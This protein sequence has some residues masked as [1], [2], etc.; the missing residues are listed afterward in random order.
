M[1][2]DRILLGDMNTEDLRKYGYQV[3]D[4]IVNYIANL[5]K[6]PV[7]AQVEPGQI[8]DAL[9]RSPPETSES[10]DSILKDLDKIILPGITHWNHPAFF[11]YFS[12]SGSAPGILGELLCSALNVNAMLWKTSPAATELEEVVLDWLR[13]M[14]GLPETFQGILYDTASVSS[15]HAMAAAREAQVDLKVREEGLAGRVEISRLRLYTSEEAHSSIEKGAILLGIGQNGVRKI[16]TEKDF[17]MEVDALERAIEDDI[18][19]GYR[20]FCVVATVGTTSTTSIDP[21]EDIAEICEKYRLWLH[22]DAA[23]GGAAA[24]LPE[25]KH[26]LKG[27]ER[28]DSFVVNPHKWLFTPLDASVFYCKR[29]DILKKAFS[30]VPEYLRTSEGEKVRNYMDYGIQL[31]RRFRA[32]KL[33][34]IFRYFG[35]KG[36][37]ARIREHIRLAQ[38]FTSWIDGDPDFQRMAPVPFSAIC[39]RAAPRDLAKLSEKSPKLKPE[40]DNYLDSLNEAVLNAV[41]SSGR[42]FLSHTRLRDRFAIRLAIGNI[43]TTESHV[44]RAWAILRDCAA[45]TDKELRPPTL[46]M[47]A[48]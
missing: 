15:L 42:V 13:Q 41:N 5:D 2:T 48:P 31:G 8:K 27:C 44:S 12:I 46:R 43:R 34:M 3:V 47:P 20:P 26:V 21:V 7:L 14:L 4:W 33:W 16:P 30:L 10:M 28:A 6:Y 38:K 35:Q 18:R 19:L 9:P 37:A 22:V 1:S 36:L 39:F 17:R 25:M 11:A 29:P 24:I 45:R 32:L 40:I 23:Y